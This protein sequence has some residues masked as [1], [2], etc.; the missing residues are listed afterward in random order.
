[1]QV[2]LCVSARKKIWQFINGESLE[3]WCVFVCV[4]FYLEVQASYSP[5]EK[6]GQPQRHRGS[7]TSFMT[8]NCLLQ[9]L[10][11]M[12]KC[13]QTD[14]KSRSRVRVGLLSSQP[15]THTSI[16]ELQPSNRLL[17]HSINKDF[18]SIYQQYISKCILSHS[19]KRK[20]GLYTQRPKIQMRE[21]AGLCLLPSEIR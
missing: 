7:D 14:R 17:F 8:I 11:Q 10:A 20:K 16:E 1:M 19:V 18:R 2:V 3:A 5:W 12:T 13:L 21:T 15:L 6:T 9:M 4:D